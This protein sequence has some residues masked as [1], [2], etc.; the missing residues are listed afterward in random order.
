[1]GKPGIV[2]PPESPRAFG[3][4]P[5]VVVA[6]REEDQTYLTP[7]PGRHDHDDLR[8]SSVAKP[9]SAADDLVELV[10]QMQLHAIVRTEHRILN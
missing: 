1:L 10:E 4:H 6:S 3:N 2:G 9:E 8:A 5:R 7:E